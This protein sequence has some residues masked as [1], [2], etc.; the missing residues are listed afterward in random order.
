[1]CT[2]PDPNAFD[3][4]WRF[5]LTIGWMFYISKFVDFID[6]FFFVLRKKTDHI[7]TLHVV[8]HSLM[9]INIWFGFKLV[10]SV[11]VA[12]VPFVN[13]FVH[14]VM[15]SY[16][17]LATLGPSVRPYLW[18]KKH[19]T[20]LQ[21]IQIAGAV[22]HLFYIG[23][24]PSCRVPKLLFVFA[25]IQGVFILTLFCLFYVNSYIRSKVKSKPS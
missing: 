11:S 14:A 5:K 4:E 24:V 10:P 6:T 21:I 17:F 23:L 16:Y 19:L 13:S 7:S 3:D 8:H 2:P 20:A 9:P 15:Y 22:C 25:V 1:M 18:W 12:F